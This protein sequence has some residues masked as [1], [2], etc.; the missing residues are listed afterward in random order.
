VG[1]HPARLGLLPGITMLAEGGP[2]GRGAVGFHP[3]GRGLEPAI[4]TLAE[5]CLMNRG[6]VPVV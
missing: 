1:I 4:M 5:G 3:V 6:L 2:V